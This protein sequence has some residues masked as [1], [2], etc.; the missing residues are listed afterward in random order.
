[1]NRRQLLRASAAASTTALFA[2]PTIVPSSALAATGRPGANDRIRLGFIGLGGR[3]RWILTGEALPGAEVVAAADCFLPR[4]HET[5]KAVPGGQKWTLYQHYREMLEKEKLDAVFVET[6]THARVLACIH[7]L[8]AGCDVYA[9]KPMS[10]TVAEGRALVQAV[11]KSGQVLQVGSQQRSMPINQ[12]ASR[13]VREGAIGRVH[14]VI[15]FNFLPGMG[16]TPRMAEPVPA[17]LDWNEWCGQTELRP[18]HHDLQFGWSNYLEYDTGGQ[19]WGVTGWGTHSLDQVQC[20]LGTDQTGPVEIWPEE[21]GLT[22]R[23][24]A[25]YANGTVLKLEGKKRGMEDLGAIFL[26]EHGKIEIKRGSF[27]ADPQDL[28][29]GAPPETKQGRGESVAHI[30]NFFACIRSRQK[31]N[32]DVETGHRATTLC[33]LVNICRIMGRKLYWDPQGE[34]FVG[35]DQVNLLLARPRRKGFELPTIG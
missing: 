17:G 1:M 13:L 16:W 18:Y 21:E 3:A 2:F 24:S 19:S 14:T 29:K 35:D 34:N 4:C 23:V 26:G 10:L 22:A 25:R 20:A 30:E 28:L 31:P 5:A 11:Q 27:T 7:V 33:H 12:F 32:A 8:Q 15:T 6:T 9:E